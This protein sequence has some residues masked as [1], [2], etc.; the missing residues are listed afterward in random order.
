MDKLDIVDTESQLR[1]DI[2]LDRSRCRFTMKRRIRCD[3]RGR[4]VRGGIRG[5]ES[6][7]EE[8]QKWIQSP[9]MSAVQ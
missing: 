6:R 8:G 4:D 5:E 3:V 9:P 2:N 7:G 1:P